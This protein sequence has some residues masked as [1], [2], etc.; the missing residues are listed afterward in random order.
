VDVS[1][2]PIVVDNVAPSVTVTGAPDGHV[3]EGAQISLLANPSDPGAN[4]TTF[5]Y[6]WKV[7]LMTQ[8]VASDVSLP[9]SVETT[10][11]EFDWT[12]PDNGDYVVSVSVT[13][14]DGDSGQ[15]QAEIIADNANPTAT[16]SRDDDNLTQEG[17]PITLTAHP[18]DVGAADTEFTY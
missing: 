8:N 16:I 7:Q 1:T 10:N 3:N 18:S 15:G 9:E 17:T 13:D 2:N 14:K 11:A 12:L 5:E 4:D 6:S